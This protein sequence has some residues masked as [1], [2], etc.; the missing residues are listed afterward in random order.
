MP[1]RG[2]EPAVYGML[3][4]LG[5]RLIGTLALCLIRLTAATQRGTQSR[6]R[7]P[8]APA[9]STA[10]SLRCAVKWANDPPCVQTEVRPCLRPSPPAV[11]AY[12]AFPVILDRRRRTPAAR[13]RRA[14]AGPAGAPGDHCP[15]RRGAVPAA[16]PCPALGLACWRTQGPRGN[17]S[18][19]QAG[20]SGADT[21]E[22]TGDCCGSVPALVRYAA[23]GPKALGRG[24]VYWKPEPP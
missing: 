23:V 4:H 1:A 8:H 3:W 15:C 2:G 12:R 7:H 10:G 17:R 16:V 19:G 9:L 11:A 20:S 6:V 22:P 13:R 5:S 21:E 24:K 14:A 18:T